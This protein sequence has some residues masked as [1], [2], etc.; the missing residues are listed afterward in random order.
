MLNPPQSTTAV[1]LPSRQL[2]Y[3]TETKK[4]TSSDDVAVDGKALTLRV[5][6]LLTDQ[7]VLCSLKKGFFPVELSGKRFVPLCFHEGLL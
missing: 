3:G 4:S 7:Q 2:N 6:N 5:I 1:T